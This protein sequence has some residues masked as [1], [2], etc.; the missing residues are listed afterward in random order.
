MLG[1]DKFRNHADQPGDRGQ[2]KSDILTS[3]KI[4]G[5]KLSVRIEGAA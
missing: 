5:K 4:V 2:R 3:G 1:T